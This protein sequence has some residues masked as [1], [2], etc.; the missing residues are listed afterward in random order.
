MAGRGQAEARPLGA[1]AS[2]TSALAGA[3]F[4]ALGT[5]SMLIACAVAE[6]AGGVVYLLTAASTASTLASSASRS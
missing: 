5:P 4:A 6:L 2:A 1:S 3:A